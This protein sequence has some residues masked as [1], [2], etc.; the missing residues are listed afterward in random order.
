M[1]RTA[2]S[3]FAS[4]VWSPM[5]MVPFVVKSFRVSFA[6]PS[7]LTVAASSHEAEHDSPPR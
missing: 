3:T 5:A 7:L 6:T 1:L 2:P 4:F